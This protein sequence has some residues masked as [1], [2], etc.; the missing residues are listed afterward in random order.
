MGAFSSNMQPVAEPAS[1][2]YVSLI[3]LC[4]LVSMLCISTIADDDVF[5][6]LATGR[7]IWENK[8]IPSTD[9]LSYPTEGIQWIPTE[10]GWDVLTYGLVAASG[11]L[12]SLQM[13]TAVI[14]I[15][16]SLLLV[17]LMRRLDVPT[18]GITFLMLAAFLISLDRMT[19][20]PHLVTILGL[21]LV[22]YLYMTARYF[23]TSNFRR[24]Y[25]LPVIFV[26]W[27]NM[28][29]G[30]LAGIFLLTVLLLTEVVRMIIARRSGGSDHPIPLP[31]G[32][33]QFR[34]FVVIF[35][36]CFVAL[37]ANPHGAAVFQYVVTHTNLKVVSTIVEWQSPFASN[38]DSRI[39]WLYRAALILC[40]MNI[41][42]SFRARDPLP[43]LLYIAFGLYSLRAVRFQTDFAMINVV[44]TS[45]SLRYFIG[46]NG[47]ALKRYI[48]GFPAFIG[49]LVICAGIIIGIPDGSLYNVLH[50]H[51]HFGAGTDDDYFSPGLMSFM[52]SNL[53]AGRPLN[54]FDIG[55]WLS[56]E[57]PGERN[58]IDSRNLDDTIANEFDSIMSM[59]PGFEAKLARYSID[60]VVLQLYDLRQNPS[61]MAETI[62]PYCSTRKEEWK[63]VY[64]DD[65]SFLYL[66]ND[67]KFK[68]TIE[69]SEYRVA[70]PYLYSARHTDFDSLIQK[71]PPR[72]E[73]ELKRKMAEEPN[74]IIVNNLVRYARQ[75]LSR[76]VSGH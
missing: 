71:D 38:L 2:R 54:H 68:H 49:S 23:P 28:H 29:P 18:P 70:D 37:M 17:N 66:R 34:H 64:W 63:L 43:A 11:T 1:Q 59:S 75:S 6:H 62:I 36:L 50:Y 15:I 7:W 26:V 12:G 40:A 73:Q 35:L 3:L 16:M 5:W 57:L 30:V 55:G 58:F 51:N 10:W 76:G 39:F 13:L 32:R 42:F 67:D 27:A 9:I 41:V 21:V 65:Y 74:G 48:A 20:R 72:L 44:G 33:N 8:S 45:M 19:P 52:K 22:M 69:E 60:Y 25:F 31:L 47:N 14:W 24:L 46:R 4:V 53:I 56:W 61:R